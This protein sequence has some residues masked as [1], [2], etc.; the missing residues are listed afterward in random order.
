[1]NN[2]SMLWN[3]P[4]PEPRKARVGEHLWS[5]RK[6]DKRVDAELRDHGKH[7]VEIQ[8]RYQRDFVYGRRWATRELAIAEGEDKQ[9]ELE[10][11]GWVV[12]SAK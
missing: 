10:E 5:M 9:R 6:D 7:G 8:F 4:R 11:C 2:D 12:D 1:M 3:A